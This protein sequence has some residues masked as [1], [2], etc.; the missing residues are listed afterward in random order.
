MR[1]SSLA[2]PAIAANLVAALPRPQEIDLDMVIAAPDPTYTEIPGST[3]QVVTYDTTSILAEA[4][5]AASS[6]SIAVTNVATG[7]AAA[8]IKRAA[9]DVQPT[10][11]SAYA[12]Q[13]DSASAFR[14]DPRWASLASA[15]PTPAG[16]VQTQLNANG[17]NSA[18]GY[19]GYYNLDSYDTQACATK[20]TNTLG[21]MAFNV[22]VE[23]DPSVEPGT[24]CTNPSSVI[25]AKCSLWGSPLSSDSATNTGQMRSSFEVAVAG[26]NAYQNNSLI[27][28]AGFS[29]GNT[30]ENAAI[31]APYDA[32]GYNTYMGATI[33]TKGT[34]SIQACAD[35]CT[36]QTAYNVKH[37]AND[38]TPPK[39]C[40]FFNTYM[41]YLNN[42]STPQGQYC[43]LYTEA[44]DASYGTNTGQYRGTDRYFVA[45]SYTFKNST[46]VAPKP[47]NGDVKGAAYQA[48]QDMTYYPSQLTSTF[49]P[50]C[51]SLLSYTAPVTTFTPT[52]T[53]TPLATF[54]TIVTSTT[55]VQ[56][57]KRDDAAATSA[58]AASTTDADAAAAST[59]SADIPT[60]ILLPWVNATDVAS[61][62]SALA[63]ASTITTA[64]VDKRAAATVPAVL[65]KYPS[66]VQS[67][68]CSLIVTQQTITSTITASLVTVTA[69][70]QTTTTTSVTNVAAASPSALTSGYLKVSSSNSNFNGL[71]A[72]FQQVSGASRPI[73]FTSDVTKAASFSIDSSKHLT[74]GGYSAFMNPSLTQYLGPAVN[75]IF[76]TNSRIY[77]GIFPNPSLSVDSSTGSVSAAQTGT[78]DK[79]NVLQ[80][81]D[82]A[83]ALFGETVFG[84]GYLLSLGPQ[85]MS[86][87][88]AVTLTFSSS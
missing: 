83:V 29:M 56:K 66:G 39:I 79:R 51:S 7:T 34:F 69:A 3:A 42:A 24:G 38:G 44:W 53:I 54:T 55:G 28:P 46:S 68:A 36:A 40:N 72:K 20:C 70:T 57:A 13:T 48:R 2:L 84:S 26:S 64:N 21:C 11:V 82:D 65:S 67:S 1:F 8:K 77:Q 80:I 75:G 41:L 49:Q 58:A 18:Y 14:A 62:S 25:Y 74:S 12:L 17:A 76:M 15:A 47:A 4:T 19:L 52:T 87:C 60:D 71:Y 88:S 35:Y 31:N 33:F 81:C 5:A 27:I 22:Y 86:G 16:F 32:Q 9:C 43:S 78:G 10:G 23:R 61:A 50:Y 45:Y 37:P 6:V 59:T 30:L 73:L 63:T 85:V